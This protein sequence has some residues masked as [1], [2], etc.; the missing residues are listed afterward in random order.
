MIK[1]AKNI[2]M[3]SLTNRITSPISENINEY[4]ITQGEKK[5]TNVLI[6]KQ[7]LKDTEVVCFMYFLLQQFVV[8]KT[9]KRKYER[10]NPVF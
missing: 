5:I 1:S 8:K 2:K 9:K 6:K 3:H 7:F 10:H 4:N